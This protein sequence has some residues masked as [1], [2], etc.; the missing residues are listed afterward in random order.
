MCN[1]LESSARFD[2]NISAKHVVG[3]K[4]GIADALSRFNL[5]VFLQLAPQAHTTP[6]VIPAEL[7]ARPTATSN[8]SS[9]VPGHRKIPPSVRSTSQRSVS[10]STFTSGVGIY[11]PIV[12]P[13][14]C[15]NRLLCYLSH[16]Y[17]ALSELLQSRSTY[18]KLFRQP[19]GQLPLI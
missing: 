6:V 9:D 1:T 7:L 10:L 4:N 16:I 12:L 17:V 2:F 11:T 19:F 14:L 5:Q 15:L 8:K 18:R 13:F 3:R